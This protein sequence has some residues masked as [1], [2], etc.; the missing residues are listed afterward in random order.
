MSCWRT[1]SGTR[2]LLDAC[3]TGAVRLI[4]TFPSDV[5]ASWTGKLTGQIRAGYGLSGMSDLDAS[6]AASGP[7]E[8]TLR[9]PCG[10]DHRAQQDRGHHR[11][12]ARHRGR[13][14]LRLRLDLGLRF[15]QVM[16]R[17]GCR[18]CG[19]RSEEAI[20]ITLC[21]HNSMGIASPD[22]VRDRLCLLAMTRSRH[23]LCALPRRQHHHH[24][25]VLH[26]RH[27]LDLGHPPRLVAQFP[28]WV[29]VCAIHMPWRRPSDADSP[30][31]EC[32]N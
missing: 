13:A 12:H 4:R 8:A 31:N 16:R 5:V 32:A 15:K 10:A 22:Q 28:K 14:V 3:P 18:R 9:S 27:L 2:R 20:A 21:G 6:W 26:A 24:L 19:Q 29:T 11:S 7:A 17:R 1:V 23:L 30:K 25:A